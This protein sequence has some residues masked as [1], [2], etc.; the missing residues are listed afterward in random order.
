[1]LKEHMAKS[2]SP[3]LLQQIRQLVMELTL[4]QLKEQVSIISYG[5]KLE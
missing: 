4:T 2:C 1:M 5:G 3:E